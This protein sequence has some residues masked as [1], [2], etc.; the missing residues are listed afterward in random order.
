ML[1]PYVPQGIKRLKQAGTNL[2]G[3]GSTLLSGRE[4]V[5]SLCYNDSDCIFF[6]SKIRKGKKERKNHWHWRYLNSLLFSWSLGQKISRMFS[7]VLHLLLYSLTVTFL[8]YFLIMPVGFNINLTYGLKPQVNSIKIVTVYRRSIFQVES[9][10]TTRTAPRFVCS[11]KLS[12]VRWRS[13]RPG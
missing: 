7:T 4:V 1:R 12:P 2:D 5:L 3:L 10:Y 13:H 9:H 11:T 6:I 8:H